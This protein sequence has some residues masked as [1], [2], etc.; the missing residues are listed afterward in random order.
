MEGEEDRPL[1]KTKIEGEDAKGEEAK[2]EDEEALSAFQRMLVEGQL[3]NVREREAEIANL[4]DEQKRCMDDIMDFKSVIVLGKAGC[5]KSHFFRLVKSVLDDSRDVIACSPTAAAAL[6][7][8]GGTIH[9]VFCVDTAFHSKPLYLAVREAKRRRAWSHLADV[10]TIMTDEIGMVHRQLFEHMDLMLRA[11]KYRGPVLPGDKTAPGILQQTARELVRRHGNVSGADADRHIS[12]STKIVRELLAD[13]PKFGGVQMILFGDFGQLPPIQFNNSSR[14]EDVWAF[15]S[16]VFKEVFP[17]SR[18]HVFTH[19]FRQDNPDFIRF[20]DEVRSGRMTP[21]AQAYTRTL[22]RPFE[23]R[24]LSPAMNEIEATRVYAK[25]DKVNEYNRARSAM[26]R[27]ESHNYPPWTHL[28]NPERITRR[29][30]RKFFD[31]IEPVYKKLGT[32]TELKEGMQIMLDT[33]LMDDL[34]NGCLGTIVEFVDFDIKDLANM[35]ILTSSWA[36]AQESRTSGMDGALK[37]I[38][39]KYMRT[40]MKEKLA[41][42]DEFL[43]PSTLTSRLRLPVVSFANGAHRTIAP[44]PR[45]AV[46]D[47]MT[48]AAFF[49]MPLKVAYAFSVHLMQGKTLD[50]IE[51][52]ADTFFADGMGYVSCSRSRTPDGLR[53][54]KPGQKMYA[55]NREAKTFME[56]TMGFWALTAEERQA[57]ME[58]TRARAAEAEEGVPDDVY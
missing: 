34:T 1:K 32:P 46:Y 24:G 47:H 26:L 12:L 48:V 53:V 27:G 2:A 8:G 22:Q 19:N 25:N 20:L 43:F 49:H 45:F 51:V 42:G 9:S 11:A 10:E 18:R 55:T 28:T 29:K 21:W 54:V 23:S 17:M 50:K 4:T 40:F 6:N 13:Q 52:H 33:N 3:E 14:T 56:N 30:V 57:R 36:V 15:N 37:H 39:N 5:G 58:E 44:V 41:C 35:D 38:K 7:I 16:E 31:T